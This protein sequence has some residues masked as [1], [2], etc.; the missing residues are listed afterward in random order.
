MT[1]TQG[2]T[3]RILVV[4]D[5][6]DIRDLL[7]YRL[8]RARF[9][10]VVAIDG[11]AALEAL[12][13]KTPDVVLLDWMMPHMTGLEVCHELRGRAAF[14]RTGIFF[15]T[16]N[17]DA[18]D[19]LL[20]MKAGANGFIYKPFRINAVVEC[21]QKYLASRDTADHPFATPA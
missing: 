6:A 1:R 9:E 8:R 16:A 21:V 7:A 20:G 13:K 5:D 10:V 12:E 2:G 18:N 3:K 14:D 4:E 19:R 11:L 17:T 15:I